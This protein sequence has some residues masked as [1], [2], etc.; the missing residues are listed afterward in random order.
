[1]K[2]YNKRLEKIILRIQDINEKYPLEDFP[3][4]IINELGILGK[5]VQDKNLLSDSNCC[6]DAYFV[7]QLLFK[8]NVPEKYYS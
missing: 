2:K 4:E 5:E 7:R 6:N 8:N 3:E 1:M